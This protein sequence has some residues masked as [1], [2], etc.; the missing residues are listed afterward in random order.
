MAA[1]KQPTPTPVGARVRALRE[2][3][4]VTQ[5]DLAERV[6]LAPYVLCNLEKG[7][8]RALAD[9]IERIARALGVSISD[10]YAAG[11]R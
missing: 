1:R 2:S 9:E 10:L 7:R 4:G 8:R 3:A 11:A 6:G 5:V